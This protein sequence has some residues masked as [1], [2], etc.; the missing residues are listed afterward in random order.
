MSPVRSVWFALRYRFVNQRN[1]FEV[2]G[3]LFEP[4]FEDGSPAS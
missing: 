2:I 3:A 4:V 1:L